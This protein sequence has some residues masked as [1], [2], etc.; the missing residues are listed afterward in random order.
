MNRHT[1]RNSRLRQTS[2][3]SGK[4]EAISRYDFM[5]LV[6]IA[7][8]TI[9]IAMV[10][11]LTTLLFIFITNAVT[12]SNMLAIKEITVFGTKRLSK[13]EVIEQAEI[14]PEDNIFSINIRHTR[15]RIVSHPWIEDASVKRSLPSKIIIA[16]KEESPLAVVHIPDKADIILNRKGIPFTESDAIGSD[17]YIDNITLPTI[18][19][20]TLSKKD[21][22]YGFYGKLYESVIGLLVMKNDGVIQKILADE[23]S[24]IEMDFVVNSSLQVQ[25]NF[26]LSQQEIES[27][28]FREPVRVKIGFDN[29]DEKFK[30]IRHIVNYMQKNKI[31]KQVWSIDLINPENV[32]IK[33]KDITGNALPK[34]I[35]AVPEQIEG[36]A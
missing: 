30:I 16:I 18:T 20:L 35:D 25:S 12:Q 34:G 32:V 7:L 6:E 29:Y 17:I 31:N 4:E 10:L 9:L 2:S 33:V 28:L 5:Q 27:T 13:E 26:T 15:L 11:S 8:K 3:S 21:G 19:G 22:I 24:G 36:G 1:T 23:E 14:F